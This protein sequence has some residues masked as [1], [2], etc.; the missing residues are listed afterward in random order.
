MDT[1]LIVLTL[2]VPLFVLAFVTK[3]RF[4]VL[5]LALAAGAMLSNLWTATLTPL[6]VKAGVVSEHPPLQTIVAVVLVLLPSAVLLFS[7]PSYRTSRLR[8]FGALAFGVMATVFLIEPVGSAFIL[9]DQNKD[10]Y[11]WLVQ[12]RVY[13]VTGGL[14]LA[15]FDLLSLHTGIGDHPKR[16]KH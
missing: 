11:N 8:L 6:F 2:L 15:I 14:V 9:T 3:R 10:A 16:G 4:G 5:G 7:G 12:N 13:I 1:A